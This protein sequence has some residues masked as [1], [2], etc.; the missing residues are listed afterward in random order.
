M[1]PSQSVTDDAKPLSPAQQRF[2]VLEQL[3]PHSAVHNVALGLR[4]T[5]QL[6]R[7]ALDTAIGEV[8]KRH[9]ILRSQFRSIDGTPV[10]MAGPLPALSSS[11][12]NL[13]HLSEAD[14]EARLSQLAQQEISTP[15]DL[16]RGPLLRALLFQLTDQEQVLL[17]VTHRIVCDSASLKLLLAELHSLYTA[18]SNQSIPVEQS[19]PTPGFATPAPVQAADMLFW[20]NQ[21]AGAPASVD[22]ATDR[23]R[24]AVQTFGGASQKMLIEGSLADELRSLSQGKDTSLFNTLL[25]AYAVLMYRYSRQEDLVLGT[26]V[27]GRTQPDSQK[28]IGP[29]ENMLALRI[30]VSEEMTF[31]DLLTRTRDVVQAA[32]AHENVPFDTVVREL[33]LER[34]M[35]RHPVFQV[36]FSMQDADTAKLEPAATWFEV[37]NPQEQFDLSID[38]AEKNKQVEVR[39]GYNSDLFEASTITRMMGHF[40]NLLESAANNPTMP[41]SRMPLLSSAERQRLIVEWNDTRVP[42]PPVECL[43]EFFEQQVE[44]TPGAVAVTHNGQSLTY[45]ELNERA[46]SVAHYLRKQG[47]GPEVLVGICVERSLEMM[48]GILGILKAGGAYVPLDPAYPKDRLAVILEDAKVR[49]LLTQER[50][51]DMLTQ[52]SAHLVRLDSAWPVIAE[53]STVNPPRSATR[54]NLDYVLFT[55]GSTGRPKGVALEHRSAVIFVHWA[56]QVFLPEEIA[57]TLFSTSISFDLSV[58]EMFVP[59]SMGG[60]VIIAQNALELPELPAAADVTLINTVPSAIAALIRMEGVPPSVRVVNLAGEALLSRLAQQI[61]QET[62]VDKVY[63]LYGPTED[64]TYSTYTLVPCG[65]EVTIGKPLFNTQTYILDQSRQVVPIGVPGELYLAGDGLARGYFGRE[66]LTN[67]RFVPNPFSD[68]PDARMYRTGDLS[69]FLAN[70]E[71]EYLGRIDNQVKI[72]GFR[73]EL[74]EIETVLS[75]QPSVESVVVI[76]REDIPGDKRLVAY[77]VPSGNS[78]SAAVLQDAIRVKLPEYMVPSAFVELKQLPLSPNGKINR[79]MLPAPSISTMERTEIIEPRND[80]E[81]TLVKIWEKVLGVNKIG[82]RDDFFDLG[83]HSLMAARV[84]TEVEKATGKDLQL[85]TLFRGATIESLAR[86]IREQDESSDPVVMEIQRGREGRLPFFA[87]V[88]PGEESLGYAMLARHMGPGQTVYKIQGHAPVT[89]GKRP[90]TEEEMRALCDEYIAAMRSVQANGPYCLGGLC[91][92]A[93]IAEQIVVRM[94]ASGQRVGLFAVFDT[95]VLQH[96]QNRLLWKIYYYGQRLQEMRNLSLSKRLASYKRV[97]EN[98]VQNLVGSKPVRVDWRETYWP[99]SFTPPRFQAPVI[100]FKRPKQ[101]FYYINDPQ[102]GW[103]ARSEAGVEIHEVDFHHSEILREPHVA[104]FGKELAECIRRL[105]SGP[106][107]ALDNHNSLAMAAPGQQRS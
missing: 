106:P 72:R 5:K 73:I 2:W 37:A 31:F 87:I 80:L 103:G 61:Y 11:P 96:S 44:R 50:L 68:G 12:V 46:N 95:W 52:Q 20:K 100:L 55:S 54:K 14:R 6:D 27:A 43:H 28:V 94:E 38:V 97:A 13:R 70:G 107:S 33:H 92:G 26:R 17:I 62:S 30:S 93:H 22:L 45:R 64:T 105:S 79:R 76:A 1:G 75:H 77:V 16:S 9:E 85:S 58:F 82:V 40:R 57:G 102:M 89:N 25:A 8:I 41:V 51:I 10:Q 32:F 90:Y 29:L 67:E 101:P 66:D 88:P 36:T 7:A 35:S 23:Q 86:I 3:H 71:I 74:E 56:R 91:D 34:D 42:Y 81:R 65:G 63:N 47:V 24:P 21:L 99:E 48:V 104:I 49:V 4:W 18:G 69:R 84:L 53:E 39:F 60:T 19:I 78:I 98:K 59:L 83:G 15:F